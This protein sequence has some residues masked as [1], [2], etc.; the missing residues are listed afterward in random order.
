MQS[1]ERKHACVP[2]QGNR[3][4]HIQPSMTSYPSPQKCVVSWFKCVLLKRCV[5]QCIFIVQR[6]QLCL[7]CKGY[8]KQAIESWLRNI[9]IKQINVSLV[10]IPSVWYHTLFWAPTNFADKNLICSLAKHD[11]CSYYHTSNL[12]KLS[13]QLQSLWKSIL[14]VLYLLNPPPLLH[15][16]MLWVWEQK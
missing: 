7:V 12:M 15:G 16:V 5:Q 9:Y 13:N 2:D 14:K 10:H 11:V 6:M 1:S 3:L 4:S 8:W